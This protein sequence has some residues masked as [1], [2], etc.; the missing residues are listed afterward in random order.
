MISK[1]HVDVVLGE[2]GSRGARH[3]ID[4]KS[5]VLPRRN[6]ASWLRRRPS[7]CLRLRHVGMVRRRG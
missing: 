3:V 7:Q 4:G 5:S 1:F 2:A 6:L